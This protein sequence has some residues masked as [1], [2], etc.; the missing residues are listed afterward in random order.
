MIETATTTVD[1]VSRAAFLCRR[2]PHRYSF[3]VGVHLP[4]ILSSAWLQFPPNMC[5]FRMY[6][7]LATLLGQFPIYCLESYSMLH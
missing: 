1:Q 3:N 6:V 4:F 2:R 7:S 5:C